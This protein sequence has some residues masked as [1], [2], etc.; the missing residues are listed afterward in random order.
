MSTSR[1]SPTPAIANQS[2]TPELVSRFIASPAAEPLSAEAEGALARTIMESR[3]TVWRSLD[4]ASLAIEATASEI[5]ANADDLNAANETIN[6]ECILFA[7]AIVQ[8]R[9]DATAQRTLFPANAVHIARSWLNEATTAAR[10]LKKAKDKLVGHNM[11]LCVAEARRQHNITKG[12]VS[13]ADLIQEGS[14]GLMKAAARFDYRRGLRFTTYALHWVSHFIQRAIADKARTIRLPVHISD[15]RGRIT[16]AIRA[17][18]TAGIADPTADQI[19][20]ECTRRTIMVQAERASKKAALSGTT[21]P[22]MPTEAEVDAAHMAKGAMTAQ[23]VALV[24]EAMAIACVSGSTPIGQHND[25]TER[26]T[27]ILDMFHDESPDAIDVLTEESM[28]RVLSGALDTL[29][30]RT[31][32]AIR[33]HL[34]VLGAG[35]QTLEEVGEVHGVSRERIRQMEVVGIRAMR[36]TLIRR[37]V[38]CVSEAGCGA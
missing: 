26:P 30:P 18:S 28:H 15:S 6:D 19:A 7:T 3:V 12:I 20:R 23:R 14:L 2:N 36:Q 17:L 11:R 24:R 5:C 4:A 31:A 9:T 1:R 29:K 21:A 27:E 13:M 34:G 22:P 38:T 32:D 33:R 37:G 8:C 25:G 10:S 16:K 35:A